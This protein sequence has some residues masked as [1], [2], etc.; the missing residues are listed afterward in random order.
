MMMVRSMQTHMCRNYYSKVTLVKPS[1]LGLDDKCCIDSSLIYVK[2]VHA[3]MIINV[4][5]RNS[6][7]NSVANVIKL[8]TTWVTEFVYKL[9]VKRVIWIKITPKKSL[10]ELNHTMRVNLT[11]L[12]SSQRGILLWVHQQSEIFYSSFGGTSSEWC[13]TFQWT[14]SLFL[15]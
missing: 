12:V 11:S 2:F 7:C 5:I 8:K 1:W 14:I 10:K 9:N 13:F 15:H 6:E 4:L 3:I